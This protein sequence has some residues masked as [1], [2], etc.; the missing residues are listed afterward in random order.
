MV[1]LEGA[2]NDKLALITCAFVTAAAMLMLFPKLGLPVPRRMI[3]FTPPMAP[4]L[5]APAL[6]EKTMFCTVTAA[7]S[8][9]GFAAEPIVPLPVA[10]VLNVAVSPV[11]LGKAA[12]QFAV[13]FQSAVAAVPDH[14]PLAA[15]RACVALNKAIEAAQISG[16]PRFDA[17]RLCLSGEDGVDFIGDGGAGVI[18]FGRGRGDLFY[19]HGGCGFLTAGR[20]IFE[21]ARFPTRRGR[22]VL[23]GLTFNAQ[24]PTFTGRPSSGN[25][26]CIRPAGRVE[27][28]ATS[29]FPTAHPNDRRTPSRTSR[30][31][32]VGC[33]DDAGARGV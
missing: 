9:I 24:L 8:V 11:P 26:E 31:F 1:V 17:R 22:P 6:P 23:R 19:I 10:A 32:R 30:T 29:L 13:V 7:E 15:W 28:N 2:L 14:V 5:K 18:S 3:P 12:D 16:T 21:K 20:D 33:H 27:C 25:L 4:I